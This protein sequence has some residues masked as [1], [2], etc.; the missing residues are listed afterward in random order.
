VRNI[1][2]LT[3]GTTVGHPRSAVGRKNS[4]HIRRTTLPELTGCLADGVAATVHW[5]F[6]CGHP[7]ACHLGAHGM[8]GTVLIALAGDPFTILELIAR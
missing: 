1:S 8:I 7:G 4:I 5:E 3:L 2:R 6:S